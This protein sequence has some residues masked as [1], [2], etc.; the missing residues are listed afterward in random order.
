MESTN[1]RNRIEELKRKREE[2]RMK[3]PKPQKDFMRRIDEITKPRLGDDPAPEKTMS[4]QLDTYSLKEYFRHKKQNKVIKKNQAVQTDKEVETE[5]IRK[6]SINRRRHGSSLQSSTERRQNKTIMSMLGNFARQASIKS[7]DSADSRK[8]SGNMLSGMLGNRIS[9]MGQAANNPFMTGGGLYQTNEVQE[10]YHS[11]S[12]SFYSDEQGSV[13]SDDAYNIRKKKNFKIRELSPERA[14]KVIKSETFKEYFM[15]SSRYL[16]KILDVQRGNR[17]K[18]FAQ[19]SSAIESE[20]TLRPTPDTKDWFVGDL[21]WSPFLPSVFLTSYFNKEEEDPSQF[22][23]YKDLVHIWNVNFTERPEK[24]LFSY[25]KIQTVKFHPLANEMIIAG[26]ESG[27]VGVFDLR[28][29]KE[30]VA[31]SKVSEKAHKSTVTAIDLVGSKN[32]NSMISAS[33]DGRICQ[34]DLA[35]LDNPSVFVD[36]ASKAIG[37]KDEESNFHGQIEPMSIGHVAGDTDF[38]YLGEP[39]LQFQLKFDA[40]TGRGHGHERAPNFAAAAGPE[41]R[42][43]KMHHRNLLVA[44]RPGQQNSP[45]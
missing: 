39:Q 45:Q 10:E 5:M 25:S 21:V 40:L 13:M 38:L 9:Q 19:T 24:E 3:R 31:K 2:R 36:L 42:K 23:T 37:K 16:E 12:G 6:Y 14:L 17:F 30:P 18:R 29:S 11:G 44:H 34:W 28:A 32:S 33:E 27:M 35:K 8:G 15:E 41:P 43:A 1:R 20:M 4:L 7:R 22:K 26:F